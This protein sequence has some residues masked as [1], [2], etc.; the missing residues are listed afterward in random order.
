MIVTAVAT[1][2]DVAHIADVKRAYAN[3][4]VHKIER[5]TIMPFHTALDKTD[6]AHQLARIIKLAL[7]DILVRCDDQ[8]FDGLEAPTWVPVWELPLR[9]FIQKVI[10]PDK[11]STSDLT[12]TFDDFFRQVKR[13]LLSDASDPYTFKLLLHLISTHFGARP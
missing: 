5:I 9:K 7:S 12:N 10:T 1:E 8:C 2:R 6:A 13:S 11:T 3:T 4:N